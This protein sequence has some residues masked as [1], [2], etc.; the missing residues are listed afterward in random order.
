MEI[1]LI[2]CNLPYF[3]GGSANNCNNTQS[4]NRDVRPVPSEY[5]VILTVGQRC[6]LQTVAE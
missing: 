6:L 4:V 5:E 2:Y 1:G 3:G